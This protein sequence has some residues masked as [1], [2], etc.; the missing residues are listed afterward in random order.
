[1]ICG[2]PDSGMVAKIAVDRIIEAVGAKIVADVYSPSLP[3]QVGINKGI[4]ELMGHHLFASDKGKLLIYTGDSQPVDPPGAFALSEL[5]V[6]LAREYRV[7]ELIVI[8][9]MIR[10]TQ[11]AKPAVFVSGTS[12]R[13]IDEYVAL[14]AGK[15]SPGMVTWMHGVIMGEALKHGVQAVCL[16]AETQGE[17]PDPTSSESALAILEKRLSLKL[18]FRSR[19][20]KRERV[21]TKKIPELRKP[22][23]SAEPTYIR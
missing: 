13:L 8:A 20:S 5:V 21:A 19:A 2:L 12:R 17:V 14:G 7:R 1:M 11:V 10:G 18:R 9:A 4:V 22:E 3:P 23:K 6:K 15:T 16:S